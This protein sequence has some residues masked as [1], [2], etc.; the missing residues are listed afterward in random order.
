MDARAPEISYGCADDGL[1]VR[2]AGAATRDVCPAAEK[3]V[4]NYLA[5]HAQAGRL[6]IDLSDCGWVDSTFAGWMVG[7]RK[8]LAAS[9]GGAKLYLTG[10]SSG[11][12]R[13]LGGMHLHALFEQRPC[14]RPRH[15]RT[16]E[17][18][19]G[20]ELTRDLVEMMARAHRELASVD[21]EN[22]RVF[23]PIADVL[24]RTLQGADS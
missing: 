23:A 8:R 1:Y 9:A 22:R 15:L 14:C 20:G 18:R 3:L 16:L 12:S 5:A 21:E 7:L 17:V 11:C 19:P 6:L 2:I 10:V 24:E 13:A 4:G